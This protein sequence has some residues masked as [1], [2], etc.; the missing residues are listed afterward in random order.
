MNNSFINQEGI[1]NYDWQKLAKK[2]EN[3]HSDVGLL[4][5]IHT[6]FDWETTY[7][8]FGIS[9][10]GWDL[11]DELRNPI[12]GRFHD[13]TFNVGTGEVTINIALLAK[14]LVINVLKIGIEE[15]IQ[16]LRDYLSKDKNSA[17]RITAIPSLQIDEII[18]LNDNLYLS[19]EC[20][21]GLEDTLSK[22]LL[23]TNNWSY[24]YSFIVEKLYIP[25]TYDQNYAKEIS[26]TEHIFEICNLL[27]LLT[28]NNAPA[29]LA[30]WILLSPEV[31]FSSI[32]DG[33][34]VWYPELKLSDHPEV[35]SNDQGKALKS[36]ISQHQKICAER[37]NPIDVGLYRLI[38]AINTKNQTQ[39]AIDLGIALEC[40]LTAPKVRDQLSLQFRTIGSLITG[41]TLEE[42]KKHYEIYKAIY[43]LRSEAVH[44]GEI[45]QQ[46]GIADRGKISS[47]QIIQE[48]IALAKTAFIYFISKGGMDKEDYIN[49]MQSKDYE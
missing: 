34:K 41:K 13:K 32:I 25:K 29:P 31:P 43:S 49:L 15:T 30:H 5:L 37:K 45:P 10:N 39:K 23:E 24:P 14:W 12:F 27:S 40:I 26:Q 2:I 3:V 21:P 16:N 28:I 18:V 7:R 9:P 8:A 17:Y 35:I 22:L 11:I 4:N 20:P 42:R 47:Y 44:N 33:N 48:G 36:L 46:E 19:S 38:S 1:N 6:D